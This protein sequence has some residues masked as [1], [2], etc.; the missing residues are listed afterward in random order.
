MNNFA[1]HNIGGREGR[2]ERRKVRGREGKE[3]RH[4]LREVTL[5]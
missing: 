1:C 5:R 4:V 2:K 3:G